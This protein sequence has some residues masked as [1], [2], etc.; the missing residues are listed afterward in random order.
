MVAVPAGPSAAFRPRLELILVA[1]RRPA[2]ADGVAR[3]PQHSYPSDVSDRS[4]NHVNLPAGGT[5]TTPPGL[6]HCP[7]RSFV[8]PDPLVACHRQPRRGR[9]RVHV[10]Q[11]LAANRGGGVVNS[12]ERCRTAV[13]QL[14]AGSAAFQCAR[15][16]VAAAVVSSVR[17]LCGS[18][19]TEDAG[20]PLI[21]YVTEEP[22]DDKPGQPYQVVA[23]FA[24]FDTPEP[25]VSH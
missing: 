13:M 6:R 15:T 17:G 12:R 24:C 25:S 16:V 4:L 7:R 22:V 1:A 20:R 19:N 21:S 10:P 9:V 14:T 8:L 11:Q 5:E 3:T 2:N 18:L 23:V